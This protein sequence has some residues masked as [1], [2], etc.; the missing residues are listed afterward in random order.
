MLPDKVG[1]ALEVGAGEPPYLTARF[2]REQG[3]YTITLDRLSKSDCN[4]DAHMLPFRDESFDVVVARH[5]LEHVL[6]PYQVL[7]E[8]MRVSRRWLL[9]V[10]PINSGKSLSWPDHLW[11][12]D[13]RAWELIFR[14][15]GLQIDGF[16][17]GNHTEQYALDQGLWQDLEWRY[18]LRK[19]GP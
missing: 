12:L 5:V 14:R 3:I 10:V 19:G 13:R 1:I 4:G 11:G 16:E 6:S 18:R 7:I 17:E 15:L 9:I 2:M 8:M